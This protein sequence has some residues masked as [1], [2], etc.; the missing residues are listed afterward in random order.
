MLKPTEA[1]TLFNKSFGRFTVRGFTTP[2]TFFNINVGVVPE[3]GN[4]AVFRFNT[5]IFWRRISF[6]L[7]VPDFYKG[8][9]K[10]PR[11]IFDLRIFDHDNKG[12]YFSWE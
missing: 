5:G 8:V 6:E 7:T 1:K 11:P 3:D 10:L 2:K 12:N 4:D 9:S